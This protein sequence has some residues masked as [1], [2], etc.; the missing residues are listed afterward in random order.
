MK[1][2]LSSLVLALAIS[3]I[4]GCAPSAA[5]AT[6]VDESSLSGFATSPASGVGITWN[7][8]LGREEIR[9]VDPA[10]MTHSLIAPIPGVTTTGP[11]FADRAR[12]V[13]YFRGAGDD[14]VFHLYGVDAATGAVLSSPS[15]P[16]FE[17]DQ[18]TQSYRGLDFG[19][20]HP[21]SDGAF[22]TITWNGELGREEI[23]TLDPATM[24]HSLIAPIPDV[25]TVSASFVG[26]TLDVVYLQGAGDD[27]V[28][29]LYGVD[30]KTGAVLSSPSMPP[31]GY[32]AATQSYH[33]FNFGAGIHALSDGTFVTITWNG[34]LAR[35]EL[36][37]VDPAT[38]THSLV[39]PIP[40][41]TTTRNSFTDVARNV[42][43]FEGAGGDGAFHL[44][45]VD[46]KTGAVLSSPPLP[47]FKYD[48][49][50]GT[51]QGFN[52]GA[53]LHFFPDAARRPSI[54]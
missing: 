10:T 35:E 36:R 51:Y 25:K 7:G 21:R 18:A 14:G 30:A 28:F 43:Y 23:R 19:I 4:C 12:G 34:E 54:E 53:G 22:V 33:G 46:A 40:G 9:K 29:H 31:F 32:D 49:A 27:G 24:A 2:A 17:H 37:A 26:A 6:P 16:P 39:A 45:G 3:Q 15:M 11:S 47:P 13:V 8:E 48:A 38:M 5:D 44:Y 20:I 52:F 50:A 42:V 1:L 41:V